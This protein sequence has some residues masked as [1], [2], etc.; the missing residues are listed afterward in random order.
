MV[1]EIDLWTGIFKVYRL[2]K[3]KTGKQVGVQP[4][5][6]N[7]GGLGNT[8]NKTQTFQPIQNETFIF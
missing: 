3:F 6:R 1:F 4:Q 8:V 7:S 2:F 5:F